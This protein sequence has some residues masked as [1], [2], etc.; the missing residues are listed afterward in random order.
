MSTSYSH[1]TA[2]EREMLLV[3]VDRGLSFR[4]MGRRLG[5]S[6]SSVSRELRRNSGRGGR[7]SPSKA[8]QKYQE[9]R[10]NCVRK[11]IFDNVEVKAVV[12]NELL[13][14]WSP[15]QISG[16]Q[17]ATHA[18]VCVSYP[19]IYRAIRDGELEVPKKCL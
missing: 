3:F 4:E 15:E 6:A 16:R 18:D 14:Y 12:T 19:T 2:S 9:R 7:Y 8:E 17:R 13:A 11:R 1:F 5:R 10:R